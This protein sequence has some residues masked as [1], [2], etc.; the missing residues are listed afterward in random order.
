MSFFFLPPLLI[1]CHF[2]HY[3]DFSFSE[4]WT[5][6]KR[7]LDGVSEEQC[8]V[9]NSEQRDPSV[10]LFMLS[11]SPKAVLFPLKQQSI[12][13]HINIDSL[14]KLLLFWSVLLMRLYLEARRIFLC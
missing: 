9:I 8:H 13:Q 7:C 1:C 2:V 14:M 4:I 3:Y 11:H 5:K 6:E 12:L 10:Q